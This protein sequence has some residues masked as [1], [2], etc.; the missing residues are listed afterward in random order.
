[1]FRPGIF[2]KGVLIPKEDKIP[3]ASCFFT[4]LDFLFP[5][6]E[7]VDFNINL[8]FFVLITL[9]SLF[10]VFFNN[11]QNKFACLFFIFECD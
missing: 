1:M 7:Q 10:S 6:T 8:P 3:F 11:L 9:A 5:H 2:D 4:N